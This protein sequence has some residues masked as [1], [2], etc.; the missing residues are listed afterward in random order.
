MN[1][2]VFTNNPLH[3]IILDEHILVDTIYLDLEILDK[4][5]RQKNTNSLISRHTYSD[6]ESLR[7]L[8]NN[9]SL[10]ARINPLHHG[11]IGE[12]E[13]CIQLGVDVIML[14][15]F[16]TVDKIHRV[17]ECINGRCDLD[18]LI[19]TP[20][21]LC[22][23]Q[24]YAHLPVR[25]FH[26][27]IN[28]L[29]IAYNLD[30]M[31]QIYSQGY[32]EAACVFLAKKKLPFGIGGVGA[33]GA[34]PFKPEWI[35]AQNIHLSSSRL[36]LSR[37]FLSKIDLSSEHNARS[38]LSLEMSYLEACIDEFSHADDTHRLSIIED[39]HQFASSYRSP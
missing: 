25:Y 16:T 36:I 27:G 13:K 10:G 5:D 12:I 23:V 39:F 14:P 6:I 8:V 34:I 7:P 18:L 33:M 26:F 38:T 4:E 1:F 2:I 9:S 22:S 32:L 11:T 15:M 30:H 20:M 31:F 29:S 28:D 3:A 35:I 19:E 17:L 24:D 21:A 37:S